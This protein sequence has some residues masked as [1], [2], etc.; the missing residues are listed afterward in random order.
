[1]STVWPIPR[2]RP[3]TK[4]DLEAMPDDGHRYEL[5]DG[6][7][8]VTPTPSWQ[9]QAAVL[10]LAIV[11]DQHCPD[12]LEVFVGPVDVVLSETTVMLPDVLVVRRSDL[13]A[14]DTPAVPL[15]VVE[16]LLPSTRHVDRM[17]KR[18]RLEAAG[19]PAYWAV[20][21]LGPA[22]TAWELR[23]GS[24]AEVA[25]VGADGEFSASQ[26]FPVV[27]RPGELVR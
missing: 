18:S 2:S 4:A 15:L 21:P 24:Y 7:L 20:D 11:L 1:M 9:H 5:I 19:C 16:V 23:D 22:L 17:L 14:G 27:V 26:P 13:G 12:D 3:L 8:I 25:T 6:A 10:H